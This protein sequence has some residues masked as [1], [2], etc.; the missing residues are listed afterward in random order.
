L[1]GWAEKRSVRR[2]EAVEGQAD[3]FQADAIGSSVVVQFATDIAFVMGILMLLG[4]RIP[5][6]LKVFLMALAVAD[7]MV[8][9]F[10]ATAIAI[11]LGCLALIWTLKTAAPSER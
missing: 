9:I 8:G 2:I 3:L 10:T 6:A 11:T 7:D 1:S 5:M 4:N